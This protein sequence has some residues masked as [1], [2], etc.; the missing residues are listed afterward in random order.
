MI[1]VDDSLPDSPVQQGGCSP[2][3]LLG[4]LRSPFGHSLADPTDSRSDG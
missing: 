3:S 2:E 4:F 1:A